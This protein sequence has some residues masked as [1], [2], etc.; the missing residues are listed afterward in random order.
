VALANVQGIFLPSVL[1]VYKL[2]SDGYFE[3]AGD[4]WQCSL[5]IYSRNRIESL[6]HGLRLS[7]VYP[8]TDSSLNQ[9]LRK[10]SARESALLYAGL[11]T[12]LSKLTLTEKAVALRWPLHPME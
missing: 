1:D 4:E 11:P 5:E 7:R 6:H 9:L 8:I 12:Y 10:E 2:D 3:H